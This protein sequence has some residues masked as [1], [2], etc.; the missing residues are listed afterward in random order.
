M[1]NANEFRL[2][3]FVY[4]KHCDD[5]LHIGTVSIIQKIDDISKVK[6]ENRWFAEEPI[7]LTKEWLVRFGFMKEISQKMDYVYAECDI[8]Q[9][10]NECICYGMYEDG[11]EFTFYHCHS[12][13]IGEDNEWDRWIIITYVRYVHELQNLYFAITNRELTITK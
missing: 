13:N 3:N 6:T 9:Y 1:I 10:P 7:T 4:E 12:S 5:T 8:T 11:D 2:G